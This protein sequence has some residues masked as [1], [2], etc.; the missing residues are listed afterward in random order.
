[1]EDCKSTWKQV[2]N[3]IRPNRINKWNVIDKMSKNYVT[4]ETKHY[5]TNVLN[6]YF[7]N[8]IKHISESMNTGPLD[9]Y[10]YLYYQYNSLFFNCY[11]NFCMRLLRN[12]FSLF[13]ITQVISMH[14]Q[15]LFWKNKRPD[16]SCFVPYYQFIITFWYFSGLIKISQSDSH[17]KKAVIQLMLATI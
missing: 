12:K 9:H 6:S 13:E 3:I 8:I 11:G 10:Q 2:N 4:Y 7:V 15:L 17:T 16:F 1:M 14:S 5:I